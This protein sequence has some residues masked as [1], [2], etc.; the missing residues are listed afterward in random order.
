MPGLRVL[1]IDDDELLSEYIKVHLE[2]LGCVVATAVSGEQGLA[3]MDSFSPQLVLVDWMM[4]GIN[5]LEV[6]RALRRGRNGQLLYIMMFT[7]HGN[8]DL[9]VD[10]FD[11]GADDFIPKPIVPRVL[12]ARIGGGAR[13]IRLQEQVERERR[14][15]HRY[16]DIV[17]VLVLGVDMGGN[18]TLLNRKACEVLGYAEHDILGKNWLDTII[19]EVYRESMRSIL[20]HAA[21]GDMEGL[22]YFETQVLARS[23]EQRLVAW[24]NN[25]IVDGGKVTG[26]LYAGEDITEARDADLKRKIFAEHL[27]QAQKI[28]AVGNLTGGITHNFNNILASIIGYAELAKE[29]ADESGEENIKFFLDSIRSVCVDARGLIDALLAFS[30]GVDGESKVPLLPPVLNDIERMLKPVL[31]SSVEF[32]VEATAQIPQV[33]INPEDV[34]QMLANLSINARD[35]M[36]DGGSIVVSLLH[37]QS[38]SGTCS[39]CHQVF[40]GE[41]IELTVSDNGSGI[42][43]GICGSIFDPFFTTKAVGKGTGLG[44][45]MVHG[46]MH[47]YDGHILMEPRAGGG[48]SVRL[49]FPV[50]Q[51]N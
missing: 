32:S 43:G 33:L 39:S 18:I 8:D 17:E 11:A 30:Q 34:H 48:T 28:Q 22:N 24:Y 25:I 2:D 46:T 49:L 37:Q 47:G 51:D 29:V 40:E 27:Q 10:A 35:A 9:L 21:G 36:G 1:I 20:E 19:P 13:M 16:L 44:L 14:E 26:M 5:G 3:M 6:C 42:S 15:A 41:F 45:S 12:L 7:Q 50:Q 38:L 31:N 4:E 23:G